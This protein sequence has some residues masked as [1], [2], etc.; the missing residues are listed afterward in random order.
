MAGKQ[1]EFWL[2]PEFLT[3]ENI[4]V[5]PYYSGNGV[6]K[7]V[8]RSNLFSPSEFSGD[9]CSSP[10]DSAE[11][12]SDEEDFLAGLTRRFCRTFIEE[13]DKSARSLHRL[14]VHLFSVYWLFF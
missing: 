2:P 11:N 12:D 6:P 9:L 13:A 7:A 14:Q 8:H 5:D 10:V 4:L 1:T 3:G